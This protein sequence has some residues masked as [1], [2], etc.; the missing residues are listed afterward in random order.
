NNIDNLADARK[1][2]EE[3][4]EKARNRNSTYQEIKTMLQLSSIYFYGESDTA[5]ARQYATAAI[6]LARA[7]N[8]HNL[9]ANGLIDLG[10]IL[11][12][13]GEHDDA[14]KYFTHALDFAKDKMGR[15]EARARL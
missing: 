10:A 1:L 7:N 15:I 14:E 11:L 3:A 13:R 9:E 2:F 6:E 12:S 5:R 4:L 8:M